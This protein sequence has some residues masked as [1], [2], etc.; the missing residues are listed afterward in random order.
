MTVIT[1]PSY[2]Q[3]HNACVVLAHS[4][5]LNPTKFDSIVGLVRGGTFPAMILSH[6]L[7]VPMTAVQYSSKSGAGD[8]K[9]HSNELP[10]LYGKTVLIVDDIADS[11]K[12]LTEVCKHYIT[13]KCVVYTAVLYY[14]EQAQ[15]IE[16]DYYWQK[17][18]TD[19]PWVIFPWEP[20]QE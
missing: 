18:P 15:G 17:I 14:K 4:I 1:H 19:A 12:T 16:P 20:T 13:N 5:K 6:L 3:L 10:N 8:N 7:D 11:G 2:D 9:N